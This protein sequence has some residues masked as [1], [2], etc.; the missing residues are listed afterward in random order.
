M[1]GMKAIII[2]KI[3]YPSTNRMINFSF[4]D[5]VI[6]TVLIVLIVK[7]TVI[8][9]KKNAIKKP[10]MILEVFFLINKNSNKNTNTALI[11]NTVNV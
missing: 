3:K 2:P 6:P 4:N 8:N 10:S 9:V 7:S 11:M 5:K 1:L